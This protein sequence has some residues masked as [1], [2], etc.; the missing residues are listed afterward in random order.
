MR[1]ILHGGGRSWFRNGA[2]LVLGVAALSGGRAICAEPARKVAAPATRPTTLH[3]KL[4]R[5]IERLSFTDID[6]KDVIQFLREYSGANIYVNW[7]VLDAAGIRKKTKISLDL[8]NITVKRA[9]GL[10]LRDISVE[11]SGPD[12]QVGSVLDGDLVL[13]T[14]GS[15]LTGAGLNIGKEIPR[16]GAGPAT[17]DA[18]LRKKLDK[19]IERL[20]FQD[21]ALKDVVQFLREYSGC[22]L[23]VDWRALE[24]SRV[25]PG[26][27]ISLDLRNLTVR[28]G[29]ELT[30]RDAGG[31]LPPEDALVYVVEDGVLTIATFPKLTHGPAAGGPPPWIDAVTALAPG[32]SRVLS[33]LRAGRIT[34]L[35]VNVGD[36]VKAGR[37]L[38]CLDDAAEMEQ[39]AQLKLECND[40]RVRA[41]QVQLAQRKAYL[42]RIASGAKKGGASAADVEGARLDV[43][44]SEISV[45]LANIE[46]KS[47]EH[48]YRQARIQVEKMRLLSPI[49]G[50][51]E[52]IFARV[53]ESVGALAPVIRVVK[54]GRDPL[55]IDVPVPVKQAMRLKKAQVARVR[56]GGGGAA[57]RGKVVS[58]FSTADPETG[59]VRVHVQVPN[60]TG[61]PVGERVTVNFPPGE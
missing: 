25:E 47:Q 36:T 42:A 35:S 26:T 32:H 5:N 57:L 40:V 7:R 58:I 28:Q 3:E 22:N 45:E 17:A 53:G 14:T 15:N 30:L 60:P 8:R 19:R 39:L 61:R 50:K 16:R 48:R 6:L 37:Q 21:I 9:L 27:K 55:W 34:K 24:R 51:V 43:K 59:T 38:V 56:I 41:A 52:R 23:H 12:G 29:I 31:D 4:A 11:R 13:V 1:T 18:D 46:R 2:V 10:V 20:S 49:D 33:F 54:V 44:I